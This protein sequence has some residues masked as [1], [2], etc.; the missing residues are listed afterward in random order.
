MARIL[1]IDDDPSLLDVLSLSLSDEGYDVDVAADGLAGLGLIARRHPDLVVSDINMPRLD[2]FTLCRRLREQGDLVPLV[3]L[4]SRDSEI[5]EA[6]GLELG[7]DDYVTK[8]FS[9]R[10]LLA[11]V[12][13]LLRREQLR[14]GRQPTTV[15][16]LDGLEIDGDRLEEKNVLQ[17]YGAKEKK[18]LIDILNSKLKVLSLLHAKMFPQKGG[19]L[20][21]DILGDFI[22]H[23]S[24][25]PTAL[26]DGT[27]Q[28]RA[29]LASR[30]SMGSTSNLVT[31]DEAAE[32]DMDKLW[33]QWKDW[34][35]T[36][37]QR[38]PAAR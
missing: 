36:Y 29:G 27:T 3:L 13:A 9:T 23:E 35:A 19:L 1:I 5:D 16:A 2:G 22:E 25:L 4:T 37:Q 31:V 7:A 18:V 34:T 14:K 6:L 20:G 32:L 21:S 17:E 38:A 12:T 30:A 28:S 24:A 33:T 8:P 15:R 10:V 11:R 26:D